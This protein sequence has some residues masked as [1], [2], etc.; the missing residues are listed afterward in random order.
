MYRV[1][2]SPAGKVE[3]GQDPY[4]LVSVMARYEVTDNATVSLNVNN[5]F[6]KKYYSMVG[7]SNQLIYGA[8]RN[9]L[10]S[11]SYRM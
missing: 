2:T 7:F 9:V 3:A 8:P 5:L 6:D 10:L 1:A 4:A 11:M